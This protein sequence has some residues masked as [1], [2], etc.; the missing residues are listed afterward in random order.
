MPDATV[1]ASVDSQG[2]EG[3]KFVKSSDAK[4]SGNGLFVAIATDVPMLPEVDGNRLGDLYRYEIATG[5]IKLVSAGL[6]GQAGNRKSWDAGPAGTAVSLP[7]IQRR[8][9]WFPGI[10]IRN[11]MFLSATW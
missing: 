6:N 11:W 8:P 2:R 4:I 9:I 1:P 3:R 7:S 10:E 5:A